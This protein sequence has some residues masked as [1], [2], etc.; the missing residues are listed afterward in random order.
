MLSKYLGK[1]MIRDPKYKVRQFEYLVFDPD[2]SRQA[3]LPTDCTSEKVHLNYF[4]WQVS[5][6]C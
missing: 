6:V 1:R 4:F 2:I 3:E 5:R